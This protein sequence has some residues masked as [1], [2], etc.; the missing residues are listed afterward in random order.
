MESELIMKHDLIEIDSSNVNQLIT[1]L[2]SGKNIPSN[3]AKA[4]IRGW[5]D[6]T[7]N[8]YYLD[9]YG[10]IAKR[11]ATNVSDTRKTYRITVEGERFYISI[12][13]NV[14]KELFDRRYKNTVSH[15]YGFIITD[16]A[17]N[18]IMMERNFP[19]HACASFEMSKMVTYITHHE[20]VPCKGT[21]IEVSE[22]GY[23]IND[24][25]GRVETLN[26]GYKTYEEAMN[27]MTQVIDVYYDSINYKG[28]V[29]KVSNT[30]TL[31]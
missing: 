9:R 20:C 12:D 10:N 21:I 17:G 31:L 28:T 1:V 5:V 19:N 3:S 6:N 29:F 8:M 16:D 24:A 14:V 4:K 18:I 27:A 25:S 22:Y 15:E 7:G 23:I 2:S 11:V 13:M 26:R 30:P